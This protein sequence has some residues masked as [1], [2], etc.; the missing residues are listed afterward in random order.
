VVKPFTIDAIRKH[1]DSD[2]KWRERLSPALDMNEELYQI[3]RIDFDTGKG[4][5]ME[6]VLA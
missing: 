6:E 1:L 2:R 5:P 3:D 4:I